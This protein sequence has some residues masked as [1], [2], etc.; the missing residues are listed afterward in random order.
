M[1]EPIYGSFA[2]GLAAPDL[3]EAA[4]LLDV[5]RQTTRHVPPGGTGVSGLRTTPASHSSVVWSAD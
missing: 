5:I 4:A 3:K 2:E 1:L